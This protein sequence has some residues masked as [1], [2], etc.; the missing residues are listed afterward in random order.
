MINDAINKI[1][2]V[3]L[4]HHGN[5]VLL[6]GLRV[7][8]GLICKAVERITYNLNHKVVHVVF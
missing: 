5:A 7:E 6:E 8:R 3:V 2:E 4:L 1:L